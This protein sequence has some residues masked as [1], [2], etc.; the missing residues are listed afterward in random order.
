MVAAPSA[1]RRV[2][3]LIAPGLAA[4]ARR[5]GAAAHQCR[6]PC[7]LPPGWRARPRNNLCRRRSVAAG[8][9]DLL[10]KAF[11]DERAGAP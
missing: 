6:R 5:R 9:T 3:S 1:A 7:A 4:G 2:P 10:V 8:G 11:V